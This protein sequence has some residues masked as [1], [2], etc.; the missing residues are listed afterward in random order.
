MHV[1][2]SISLYI[3]FFYIFL[4][5]TIQEIL[6]FVFSIVLFFVRGNIIFA[7]SSL[8][9]S[10]TRTFVTVEDGQTGVRLPIYESDFTD[11]DNDQTVEDRFCTLA[12]EDVSLLQLTG[13]H[14]KGTEIQVTFSIDNEGILNVNATRDSDGIDFNLKV[15]GVKSAAELEKSKDFI[16]N[17]SV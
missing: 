6:H 13:H 16:A 2:H 1:Y 15:A 10:R 8:P 9:V 5:Y 12:T 14:P 11:E 17:A 4:I 3:A 7:N